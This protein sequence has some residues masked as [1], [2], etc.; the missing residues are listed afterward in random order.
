MN[1]SLSVKI[2]LTGKI[3]DTVNKILCRRYIIPF[4]KNED[5]SLTAAGTI[6]RDNFESLFLNNTNI[7][8]NEFL[9]WYTNDSNSDGIVDYQNPKSRLDEQMFDLN[10]KELPLVGKFTV[11]AVENDDINNKQWFQ[12]DSIEY[13]DRRIGSR[14]SLKVGDSLI[15][16]KK[17][18]TS[19]RYI[20]R[21]I[22][23]QNTQVMVRLERVEGYD[24]I[25][26]NTEFEI[27]S[28]Y[29]AN[30]SINVTIGYDEYNVIFVRPI[31]TDNNVIGSVWS[32]GT[33]Y[34]TN[35]L[36]LDTS[37]NNQTLA[38]YYSQTVSDYGNLL[39]DMVKRMIPAR[40]AATPEAPVLPVEDWEVYQINNHL[41]DTANSEDLKEIQSQI[42]SV[43]SELNTNQQTINQ[44]NAKISQATTSSEKT[45]FKIQLNEAINKRQELNEQISTY[46]SQISTSRS[47]QDLNET[48]KYRL[49]GFF[50][51]PDDVIQFRIQW[52]YKSADGSSNP[53]RS[54]T[55]QEDG[56]TETGTFSNWNEY[57]TP[58]RSRS[59]DP[60][61]DTWTWD[62]EDN[63]NSDT[64]NINQVDIPIRQGEQVEVRIKSISQA[65]W[66][67]SLIES[68]WSDSVTKTFPDELIGEVRDIDFIYEENIKDEALVDMNN[69]LN[70]L[71][72]VD[73]V[74]RQT[75]DSSGNIYGHIDEQILTSF[76]SQG[77]SVNLKVYLESLTSR[78]S[79]LEAQ[80]SRTK[81]ELQVSL[82]FG[83]EQTVIQKNT[84]VSIPVECIDF[85]NTTTYSRYTYIN[86]IYK[87]QDYVLRIDNIS[88]SDSLELL[89]DRLYNSGDTSLPFLK[90]PSA[91]TI[92]VDEDDKMYTQQDNQFIWF[93]D[94]YASNQI[95][96][97]VTSGTTSIEN[98]YDSIN[99]LSSQGYNI[100]GGIYPIENLDENILDSDPIKWSNSAITSQTGGTFLA[101]VHP[102]IKDPND[103][104]E[105][106]QN[107]RKEIKATDNAIDIPINIYFRLSSSEYQDPLEDDQYTWKPAATMTSVEQK[108]RYVKM[109]VEK[110]GDIR[111][112]EYTIHFKLRRN[113]I[114]QTI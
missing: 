70:S 110:E 67:D 3:E 62:L 73:H 86:K 30:K 16:K 49:R 88:S 60:I 17:S 103:I 81:G 54:L 100:G 56:T 43:R 64:T 79:T 18:A 114:A 24:P 95:Y 72:V 11:V 83:G 12:L 52:R 27:Y 31:N 29:T 48:P 26:M 41:T 113:K 91:Q 46:T 39:R 34:Y 89:S 33:A 96:S 74:S 36:T 53:E 106:A 57:I 108:D 5:G 20:I 87:V 13:T 19:T 38:D 22:N 9:N 15:L 6:A 90:F 92:I 32:Q 85:A 51:V 112:S 66:P 37:T 23:N 94:N 102:M 104:V 58:I 61:T 105:K 99:I 69:Q 98:Y 45:N 78:I 40:G 76:T 2:D 84:T 8:Q 101:T 44:L 71:G 25:A 109:Y 28:P 68:E 42:V 77:Q 7:D 80:L 50:N 10:Y 93:S 107:E 14:K 4:A 65:G 47:N 111:A 75:T 59:Y 63:A 21:E 1:P 35:N 55:F 82:L 97:G